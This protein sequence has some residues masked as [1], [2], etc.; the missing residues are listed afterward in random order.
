VTSTSHPSPPAPAGDPDDELGTLRR[1][2][3]ELERALAVEL[4]ISAELRAVDEVRNSFL[5]AVSHDLRTPL[6]AIIGL[7]LT[8]ERPELDPSQA[9]ELASRIAANARRLDRMVTDLLDLDRLTSGAIV[10]SAE[11]ADVGALVRRIVTD[12][13]LLEGRAVDVQATE[14]RA[15]VDVAQV[16]RIVENLLANAVRHTPP[17]AHLWVSVRR[18]DGGA[19][20]LVEDDGPGVPAEQRRAI[21]EPFRGGEAGH[22]TSVGI[23][24]AIVSRFAELQGGRSWVEE[25]EG[26]GASFRVWLPE[27]LGGGPV[28]SD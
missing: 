1:R 4:D 11:A 19:L 27:R 23:G 25:R 12:S 13:D 5:A 28:E 8:L 7:A 21:F 17:D 24:L 2:V 22:G 6:A 3:E 26:G 18:D 10:S 9:R 15:R 14:A 16:E 20:I